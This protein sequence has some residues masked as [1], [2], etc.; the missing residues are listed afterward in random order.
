MKLEY[1]KEELAVQIAALEQLFD[2]VQIM[3][4][5][6][7]VLLDPA[8]MEP[9]GECGPVPM[10]DETGRATV[11]FYTSDAPADYNVIVEGVSQQGKIIQLREGTNKN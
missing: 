1:T 4:P 10:L 7:G 9:R 3:D 2:A 8:T 11:E 6:R 5:Y